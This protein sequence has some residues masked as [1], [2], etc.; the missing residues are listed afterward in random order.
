MRE[1]NSEQGSLKVAP[2][3]IDSVKSI[4]DGSEDSR[5]EVCSKNVPIAI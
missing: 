4:V 3:R 1:V 2:N 5:S